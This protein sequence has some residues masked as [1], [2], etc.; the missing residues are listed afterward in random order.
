[1][2]GCRPLT[3][4]EKTQVLN[5]ISGRHQL[6]DKLIV[7]FGIYAGFR[8]SEIL[9]LRVKDVFQ[10]GVVPNHVTVQRRNVKGRREGR[11]VVMHQMIKDAVIQYLLANLG[12]SSDSPLFLNQG[13]KKAISRQQAWNIVESAFSACGLTGT[14]GTHSLRKTFALN[15][16]QKSGHCL[17][18][19]KKALG[20]TDIRTTEKYLS[21]AES[22]VED[23]ILSA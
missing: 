13:G 15:A 22:E 2:K 19:T 14:L 6:R 5:S 18:K 12:L 9:S 17:L 10:N 16:Y 4:T 11:T 8:I 20:H 23:L 7:T 21:F 1:M 3:E